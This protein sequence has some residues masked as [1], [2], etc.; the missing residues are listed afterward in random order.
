MYKK[1]ELESTFIE[2][3]NPKKSNT[4]VNTIHRHPKMN[5]TEQSFKQSS[6]KKNQAQKAVFLLGDFNIDALL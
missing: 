4:V 3:I 6:E 2:I 1:F 5:V